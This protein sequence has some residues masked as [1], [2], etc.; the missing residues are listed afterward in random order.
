MWIIEGL[1]GTVMASDMA[2][3]ERRHKTYY[4]RVAIPP[5]LRPLFGGRQKFLR[6]LKTHSLAEAQRL[7]F[8]AVALLKSEIEGKRRK[9]AGKAGGGEAFGPAMV[10]EAMRYASKIERAWRDDSPDFERLSVELAERTMDH[11]AAHGPLAQTAMLEYGNGVKL[12]ITAHLEAWLTEKR[13]SERTKMDNRHAVNT[14]AA[15][16]AA[17]GEV[18]AAD[19]V[20]DKIATQFKLNEIIAKEVHHKTANKLLSGLR[21]YW[22]WLHAHGFVCG[23]PWMGKS[24][25]KHH[26]P[27]SEQER[28]F[29]D[30]EMR[31]LFTG[32]ALDGFMRD[33]MALA[34]LSGMRVE[35]IF[36]LR[37]A[38]CAGGVFNVR[39]SKTAAGERKVPIHGELKAIVARRCE[40]KTPQDF[41]IGEAD[42]TGH[43]GAR[44]MAFS[45]RFKTYRVGCRVDEMREGRRR[46]LVN[47]HSF[48]RWFI[49]KAD[50]AG[51]R[52]EDIE[53]VVGH[54][55][56]GMSIG[57]YS[58]G[59]TDEQRRAV[60]ESVRLPD[61]V[62]LDAGLEV[63]TDK[64]PKLRRKKIISTRTKSETQRG[65]AA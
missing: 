42:G 18:P 61:G 10:V 14:F 4:V 49:T 39:R 25:P 53:R 23:N 34:A 38:D 55:P 58:S 2:Y 29:T 27:R 17:Q 41:L 19:A 37:V 50:Q 3:L 16:M 1:G 28:A 40:G 46:S 47:Y 60:V 51:H 43:G 30:D 7:R 56:Q 15:W 11:G 8:A 24:L 26:V 45:K 6:S 5:A 36:Q 57:H 48:R 9:V 44:A 22:K 35:E 62:T 31:L 52:R 33:L 63:T 20:S 54:K 64:V 21:T 13:Y 32:K 12:P 65:A 59:M